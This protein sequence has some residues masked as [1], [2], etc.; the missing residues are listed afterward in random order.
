MKAPP[1]F[2]MPSARAVL[3]LLTLVASTSFPAT[4]EDPPT[5][6]RA[7]LT[8]AVDLA[9][10]PSAANV[11]KQDPLV[12]PPATEVIVDLAG[13]DLGP[14]SNKANQEA[15]QSRL[16]ASERPLTVEEAGGAIR[17]VR[18]KP[19]WRSVAQLVNP[20]APVPKPE[21]PAAMAFE[22]RK[23]LDAGSPRVMQ[24]GVQH[25]STLSIR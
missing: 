2:P 13:R 23:R 16:R 5:P 9:R 14:A 17:Y 22:T 18:R 3:G 24:E 8:N 11:V 7:G 25:E 15:A 1:A 20:F 12:E 6:R 21:E 4:A 19:G 10:T